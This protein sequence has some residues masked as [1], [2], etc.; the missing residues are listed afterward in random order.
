MTDNLELAQKQLIRDDR[1]RCGLLFAVYPAFAEALPEVSQHSSLEDENIARLLRHE[2]TFMRIAFKTEYAEHDIS[3][4]AF[5]A[6]CE[7]L[8]GILWL[9]NSLVD[10]RVLE[11]AHMRSKKSEVRSLPSIHSS[12]S[13]MLCANLSTRS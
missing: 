10:V 13:R 11:C 8:D 7:A 6:C 4:K 1:G 2:I 3:E 9:F 5:G 12:L